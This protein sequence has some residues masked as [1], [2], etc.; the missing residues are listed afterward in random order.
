[1]P[2]ELSTPI[3]TNPISNTSRKKKGFIIFIIFLLTIALLVGGG[4]LIYKLTTS[5]AHSASNSCTV[6]SDC[7]DGKVCIQGTCNSCTVNSDCSDGKV[8][9]QGKCTFCTLNSQCSDGKSCIQ[10][11][12]SPCVSSGDCSTGYMCSSDKKCVACTPSC[13]NAQCGDNDSCGGFCFG[14]CPS[15]QTCN[16]KNSMC[17]TDTERISHYPPC[18]NFTPDGG[19]DL[20]P[21][22]TPSHDDTSY[23]FYYKSKTS[24]DPTCCPATEI[25]E[26]GEFCKVEFS[27][28]T[29]KQTCDWKKKCLPDQDSTDCN[30]TGASIPKNLDCDLT[31]AGVIAD[32]NVLITSTN[33]DCPTILPNNQECVPGCK[34]G[35]VPDTSTLNTRERHRSYVMCMA[36][37]VYD[38][39]RCV[40]AA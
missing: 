11:V 13:V 15:G 7:S 23:C 29:K 19:V 25:R 28:F 20:S 12:C 18:T 31:K 24:Q 36:G 27:N 26:E 9:I 17:E 39:A 14:T 38:A 35:Y 3:S 16:A 4:I 37:S 1:M 30:D 5:T 32:P 34:S 2:T 8:C 6:N 40:P 22:R 10:G 33:G 21:W